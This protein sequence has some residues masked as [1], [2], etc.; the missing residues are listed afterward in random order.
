MQCEKLIFLQDRFCSV[1]V[2]ICY[3]ASRSWTAEWGLIL[4]TKVFVLRENVSA[5][6]L[7]A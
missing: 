3:L 7:E 4:S 1:I 6:N 2:E 5:E